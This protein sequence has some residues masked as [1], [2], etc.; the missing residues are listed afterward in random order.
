MPW[1]DE[2]RLDDPDALRALD[3]RDSL[4][5]LASAGAQVRRALV[6][7]EEAGVDATGRRRPAALRARR[8]PRR[9]LPRLRRARPPRRAGFAGARHHPP[10]CPAARLGRPARPR[11]RRLAV[12]PGRRP[13]RPRPP[14]PPVAAPPCSPSAPP[15]R[16]S[17][18]SAPGRAACTSTSPCRRR[19][20]ARPCGR[21][22]PRC[23]S[24]PTPWAS[25]TCP[26]PSLE[27]VRRRA[28]RGR[29][30]V[31]AQLRGLRQ[32]RQGARHRARRD[33]ARR[34]RR[35]PAH[36]RRRHPGREHA[37]AHR[38]GTRH[39]RR[40]T[41]CRVA[42]RRLPR[43]AVRLGARRRRHAGPAGDG[44]DIFADPYLDGPAAHPPRACSPCATPTSTASRSPSPMPSSRSARDSGVTVWEQQARSGAADRAARVTGGAHRLRGHLPRPRAG[45]RPVGLA[46]RHR[47][48][49]PH[50]LTHRHPPEPP[51][52]TQRMT[53]SRG[54]EEALHPVQGPRTVHPEHPGAALAEV[55]L[56]G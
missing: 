40:P 46:P 35:R 4:R 37:R 28:R 36:R 3:T 6:S 30:G 13:A 53:T 25:C 1:V 22:S 31:P 2:H 50:L 56:R 21:S 42:G 5:S 44:D 23:S 27:R 9:V 38:P 39:A 33:R 14:R 24:P 26:A 54:R 41:G 15:A 51:A 11:H 34:A 20:R 49:R 16:R 48:A 45:P 18:R 12:R 7:A 55:A 29:R 10:R 32:P 17:P 47:A 52:S 43:R 19:R 8:G